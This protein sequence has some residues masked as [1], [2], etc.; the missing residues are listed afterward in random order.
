MILFLLVTDLVN[1]VG[2]TVLA[3]WPV[4][5][6][7]LTVLAGLAW[8]IYLLST[9]RRTHIELSASGIRVYQNTHLDARISWQD[10]R[11]FACYVAP[12]VHRTDAELTYE[13]SSGSNLVRWSCAQRAGSPWQMWT[14]PIPF[15]EH[16][17][18]MRALAELITARTG[19]TLY[20]LRREP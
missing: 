2:R 15:E 1:P 4:N 18:Q 9:R 5:I 13:L 14:A 19:L 17:A 7:V 20:D 6:I 3:G 11:L 8:G 12:T 16:R 10:A